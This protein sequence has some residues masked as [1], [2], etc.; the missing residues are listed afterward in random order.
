L[1]ITVEGIMAT[2]ATTAPIARN[3]DQFFL[4]SAIAM[5]LLVVTGFS[6]QLALGRSTFASPLHV[7]LHAVFFMGWV[8]IYVA[9]NAFAATGAMALHRR[10]GWIATGWMIAM[11]V[12]GFVVTI[13]M[14]RRGVTPF[15]FKP[16][17]FL[18]FDPIA[19]LAFACL[20]TAAVIKRRQ[21]DWHRRLHFCAMSLLLGPAFGRL[22]PMPLFIP[23]AWEATVICV[24]VFPAIGVVADL[25]RSG[26]VHRAWVWGIGTM[27]ASV[28][29]TEI[30]AFG[31][32]GPPIYRIVTAG[33]P[34][35]KVA[36]LEFP[37]P[38]VGPLR[39]GRPASI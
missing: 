33:S 17:H 20:T 19:V 28:I 2:Q 3:D 15:F 31:P 37:Q 9:Q 30:V 13:S 24:L 36:P 26:T 27:L 18:I 39:T 12:L 21:T 14:A 1:D 11:V 38:P 6:T 8:A 34:G 10:L 4:K 22:L 5:A 32:L 7:H 29:L 23:F 25:R 16:L 35:A